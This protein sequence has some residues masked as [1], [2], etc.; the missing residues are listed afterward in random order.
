VYYARA[1]CQ[2]VNPNAFGREEE[3]HEHKK[4]EHKSHEH[5]THEKKHSHEKHHAA[6]GSKSAKLS[7]SGDPKPKN[8]APASHWDRQKIYTQDW[9]GAGADASSQVPPVAVKY[10]VTEMLAP[11]G[12]VILAGLGISSFVIAHRA[13]E[14]RA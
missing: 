5:K 6:R 3:T 4:H 1:L 11:L 14:S 10:Q 7:K 9:L 13:I 8:P 2:R 12:Y